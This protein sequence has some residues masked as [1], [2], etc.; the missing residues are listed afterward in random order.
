M[1]ASFKVKADLS[2]SAW[3][4]GIALPPTKFNWILGSDSLCSL[5][6]KFDSLLSHFGG[7]QDD[8]TTDMD[9]IHCCISVIEEEI[10]E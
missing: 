4:K 9:K 2:V 8:S 7:Y 5:W 3:Q 10:S 6:S 1:I